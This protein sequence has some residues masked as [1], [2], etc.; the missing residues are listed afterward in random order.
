MNQHEE[1]EP[2]EKKECQRETAPR[3][4]EQPGDRGSKQQHRAGRGQSKGAGKGGPGGRGKGK[5]EGLK[6]LEA[7]ETK[8]SLIFPE[9]KRSAD[10][11]SAMPFLVI[12]VT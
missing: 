4:T 10:Q 3:R 7:V 12:V 1:N 6:H 2:Q 5:E 11:P 8:T 9:R